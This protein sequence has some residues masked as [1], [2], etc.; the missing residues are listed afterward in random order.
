MTS[1]WEEAWKLANATA[2]CPC[3]TD[4]RRAVKN[5]LIRWTVKQEY[6]NS[7]D[8]RHLIAASL[9]LDGAPCEALP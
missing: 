5:P 3:R 9:A 8:A 6:W 2:S 7:D 1:Q 4:S